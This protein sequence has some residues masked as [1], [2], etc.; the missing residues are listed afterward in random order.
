MSLSELYRNMVMENSAKGNMTFV[1]KIFS[2]LNYLKGVT[3]LMG[4]YHRTYRNY[5]SIIYNDFRRKYPLQAILKSGCTLTIPTRAALVSV[6]EIQDYDEITYDIASETWIITDLNYMPKN[7]VLKIRSD[8]QNGEVVPIFMQNIYENIPVKGKAVIDVG[9][10]VG[11]SCIYFA[12]K[13]ARQVIGLE[14]FP[15]NHRFAEENVRLNNLTDKVTV[16]MAACGSS[17]GSFVIDRDYPST[18][19]SRTIDGSHEGVNIPYLTLE[20]ILNENKLKAGEAVLK[21]DCE[22]C[23]YDA[24]L[25]ASKEVLRR[26]SYVWIEYHNGYKNLR[27]KLEFC[28]FN[29][30][31]TRPIADPTENKNDPWQFLGFIEAQLC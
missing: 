15:K 22:G 27:K 29:V 14:P 24:I 8:P 9:A 25:S 19:S 31:V 20:Q 17:D 13:G 2:Y 6:A 5:Y 7:M 16:L 23:E 18:L 21:M 26:F 10:N 3:L 12:L 4:K 28:G 11:D 1:D 30:T